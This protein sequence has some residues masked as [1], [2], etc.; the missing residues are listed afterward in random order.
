MQEQ[1]DLIR[2][3]DCSSRRS[4]IPSAS[5]PSALTRMKMQRQRDTYPEK[6]LRSMLHRMGFRYRTHLE[7]IRGLRIH[8]DILFPRVKI[9]LFV[10]GCFWHSCPEHG[11]LPKANREWWKHK[12]AINTERDER[13]EKT[14]RSQGWTVIRI[15]E[16]EDPEIASAA[17]AK[18]LREA[19]R[20]ANLT[21][22]SK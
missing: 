13:A 11:T 1:I 2:I 15:W 14:L 3:L 20:T 7:P 6:Q 12:L 19:Y 9:A 4:N 22:N 18:T 10:D 5:S 21:L 16:H 17:I 8:A